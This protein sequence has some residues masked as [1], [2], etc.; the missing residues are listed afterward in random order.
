MLGWS[1][2]KKHSSE[3][4]YRCS[5]LSYG[6]GGNIFGYNFKYFPTVSSKADPAFKMLTTFKNAKDALRNTQDNAL[7]SQNLPTLYQT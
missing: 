6:A 4:E 1:H 7:G 2:E 3:Q 5:I